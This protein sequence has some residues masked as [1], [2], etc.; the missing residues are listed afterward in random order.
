MLTLTPQQLD[1]IEQM[2]SRRRA[3]ALLQVLGQVWPAVAARLGERWPAFVTTS[4]ERA[5]VA[6]L[7]SAA[8]QA[9]FVSLCCLW[10]AG[11][12][13]RPGYE[14]AAAILTSAAL[15]PALALYQLTQQSRAIL[16]RRRTRPG[17]SSEGITEETFDRALATLDAALSQAMPG[18]SVFLDLPEAAALQACD[19][20]RISFAVADAQ[21]LQRYELGQD[22]WLRLPMPAWRREPQTLD[23]APDAAPTLAV[24]SHAPSAGATARLQL[25]VQA[26]ASCGRLHPA[27]THHSSRGRLAWQGPDAAR[28]SLPL[29]TAS[30]E[31]QMPPP[32]I[33]H[34]PPPETQRLTVH[35]CGVRAAGAPLGRVELLLQVH[36]ATQHAL[37]VRHGAWP[38]VAWPPEAGS[39][40]PSHIATET[41]CRLEADGLP[42]SPPSWLAAWQQLQGLGAR[43]LAQ[44]GQAWAREAAAGTAGLQ[45]EL[46][47]L[48]GHAALSW[49]WQRTADGSVAR[50]LLGRLDFKALQ[51]DLRMSGEL[52]WG[53]CRARVLL[54]AHGEVDWRMDLDEPGN[55]PTLDDPAQPHG[56]AQARCSWRLPFTARI[57]PVSTGQPALLCAGPLAPALQGAVVGECGL[58]PRPDGRG[59]AWFYRLAVEAAHAN[60]L[61][62]DP[63][64]GTQQ[65]RRVLVPALTLVDWS[66]G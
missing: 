28:L 37:D 34:T 45:A 29:H 56:L 38:A 63:F 49:G 16:Q 10:G 41:V 57:E 22:G 7:R 12:E 47:A 44:L 18:H 64:C 36:E 5:R 24:L 43:G 58:R 13:S 40:A 30:V 11:F 25:A 2:Q 27:V 62:Q 32:G 35:S 60:L 52:E 6:G 26:H 23:V 19:L 1:R 4:V 54:R 39:A 46:S 8:E 31:R 50:R 3:A 59:H 42:V 48:N 17:G 21:P 55:E 15:S 66:A 9:R 61:R 14:W 51:L 33:G 65:E 53:D 20:D